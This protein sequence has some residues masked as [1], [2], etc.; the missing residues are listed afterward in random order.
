MHSMR[1]RRF[2]REGGEDMRLRDVLNPTLRI[3][4]QACGRSLL[5]PPR[6]TA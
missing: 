5:T 6:A 1:L 2:G 4:M 3:D